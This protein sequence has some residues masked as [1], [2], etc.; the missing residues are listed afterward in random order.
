MKI[1]FCVPSLGEREGQ[2]S[3]NLE[4]LRRIAAAGVEVDV[5]A[6]HTP[7]S[8]AGLP[9]VRL[10]GLPRLPAWQWGNQLLGLVASSARL[11]PRRYDLVHADA[12]VTLRRA[13]VVSCHTVNDAWLRL[14]EHVWREPGLR[15]ANA[16]AATRFKA[17]LELGQY[18]RAR[19]V[20]ANSAKTAADLAERGIEPSKITVVPFGVDAERFRP[21]SATERADARALLG[22]DER[23]FVIA[24]VGAH[25]PRK[26]LPEMLDALA[27]G[28]G[29]EHLVVAGDRRGEAFVRDAAVRRL[30]VTMPG[31]VADV[32]RVYRAADVLVYPSRYDAFGLAVLEAMACGLPVIVSRAAGAHEIV[33]DAGSVLDVVSAP[34]I[35]RALD[36]LRTDPRAARMMGAAG[37]GIAVTRTWDEA[38]RT[39]LD[40]YAH[41]AGSSGSRATSTM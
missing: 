34:Q 3:A 6:G 18:R 39:L 13:D 32:R 8:V 14:S 5:F 25:G 11:R 41:L 20:V 35:R 37:R 33:G 9:G 22:I 21:P 28:P 15:G 17:R 31:K 12:G 2:G 7:A 27:A 23:V 36:A 10:F 24:F 16:A 19:A 4:L 29:D 1:A 40:L 38:G 30:P 26:G